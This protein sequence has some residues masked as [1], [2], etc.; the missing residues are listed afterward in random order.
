VAFDQLKSAFIA[1]PALAN[2]DP[3][4]ETILECDASGWATGSVLS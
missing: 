1:A 2:F 3:E 4:L